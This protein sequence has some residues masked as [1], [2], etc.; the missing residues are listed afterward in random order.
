M[1]MTLIL[2]KAP[3]TGDPDEANRLLRPWY[4]TEDDSAF[5]PSSDIAKVA[6]KLRRLYPYRMLTNAETVERMSEKERAE[7]SP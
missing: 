6:D 5:E 4:E 3:V 1:S 2:W 7:Y